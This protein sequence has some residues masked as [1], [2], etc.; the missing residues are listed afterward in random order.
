[1]AK[2]TTKKLR[3]TEKVH[4]VV[5]SN[6]FMSIAIASLAFN[7][8]LFVTLFV[9]SDSNVFDRKAYSA[10]RNKYC[11]NVEG[12]VQRANELGSDSE[13]LREWQITCVSKDFRPFYKEA[14]QK[15]EAHSKNN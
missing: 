1:M 4:S 14:I 6:I 11:A 8:F 3:I 13:A 15:F 2:K 7:I 12:V 10:V 5:K 9:L